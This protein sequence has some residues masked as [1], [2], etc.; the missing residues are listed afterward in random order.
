MIDQETLRRVARTKGIS[1]LSYAEKDYFQEIVMLGVSREAPELAFKG[2]T[3]LYKFHGLNR[4]SEDLDF[5]GEIGERDARRISSYI[6]NFGYG[7]ELSMRESATGALLTFITEGFLFQGTP[8]SLARVQ[9]DVSQGSPLRDPEWTPF[10]SLYQDIPS[11]RLNVMAQEEIMAEK[12][13]ALLVRRKARDAHD[14]W[15]LLS[16]GVE[17]DPSLVEEKLKPYDMELGPELL[18]EAL[19][20]CGGNWQRE[21]RPLMAET[22]DFETVSNEIRKRL[23]IPS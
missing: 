5:S 13:R 6:E 11:F 21:L 17:M 18:N 22:P 10:F 14:I 7:T 19:E 16:K 4:F 23:R 15:F 1:N 2:G 9:M 12:V 20:E 3:A 8:E